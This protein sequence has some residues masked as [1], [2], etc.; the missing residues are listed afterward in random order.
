MTKGLKGFEKLPPSSAFHCACSHSS[1]IVKKLRP[2]VS[3]CWTTRTAAAAPA[4]VRVT[5]GYSYLTGSD[6]P[7]RSLLP[8]KKSTAF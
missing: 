8:P 7:Q 5:E 2:N 4:A 6:A 3:S 1:F